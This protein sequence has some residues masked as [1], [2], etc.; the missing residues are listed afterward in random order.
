MNAFTIEQ[1]LVR[2]VRI[3]QEKAT[4]RTVN[5]VNWF[6]IPAHDLDKAKA[7]YEYV[8]RYELTLH[9]MGSLRMAWF[10][11][12]DGTAGSTGTL[13]KSQAYTPSHA[14]TLVYFY[15]DDIESTIKRVQEKGGN[16]INL[17]MSFGEYGFVA[18]F[19][20]SE[21]NRVALHSNQ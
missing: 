21:G 13:I 17:K 8:F 5:P 14:G 6:E 19:E 12:T 9:E 10:P 16:V 18:H 11:I 2:Y 3:K 7:F 4:A 1:L 15:V 20:E